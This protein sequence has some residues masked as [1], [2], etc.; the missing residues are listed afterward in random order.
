MHASVD[1]LLELGIL[2]IA[3]SVLG[4]LAR[5]LSLSPVP[6]YLIAGLAIGEGGILEVPASG[7]YIETSAQIGL[8]LLLLTLGL[9][10]S[11]E[12]FA[13]LAAPGGRP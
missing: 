8:V 1:L 13:E 12:D 4:T 5:R 11:A 6:L 3:L 10:F 9:E 2:L 7:D